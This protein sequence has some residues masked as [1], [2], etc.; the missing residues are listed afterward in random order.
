MNFVFGQIESI[1]DRIE[2]PKS[3]QQWFDKTVSSNTS[4][5]FPAFAFFSFCIHRYQLSADWALH[6]L[7]VSCWYWL[8]FT[9]NLQ[10]ALWRGLF[11][12]STIII[13]VIIIINYYLLKIKMSCYCIN[14][15]QCKFTFKC[16]ILCHNN[17]FYFWMI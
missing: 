12:S 17:Y 14:Y 16:K 13:T 10:R 8:F 4:F 9:A 2:K 5:S 11:S 15:I 6:F 1:A 3:A 7:C